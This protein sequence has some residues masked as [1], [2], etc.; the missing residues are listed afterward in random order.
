[1]ECAWKK[2]LGAQPPYPDQVFQG[3]KLTS[4]AI[5]IEKVTKRLEG[6]NSGKALGLGGVPPMALKVC[7][8]ILCIPLHN[9]ICHSL[10]GGV[11][12]NKRKRAN[13]VPIPFTRRVTRTTL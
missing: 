10:E 6:L 5:S 4:M 13:I 1:M 7:S 12:P 3:P 2:M 11:L 9:I 8:D